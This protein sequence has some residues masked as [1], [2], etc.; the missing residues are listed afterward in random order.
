MQ[1]SFTEAEQFLAVL[2]HGLVD[3]VKY[4]NDFILG[5]LKEVTISKKVVIDVDG[6][7]LQ[8]TAIAHDNY[9]LQIQPVNSWTPSSFVTKG[10]YV[11]DIV[12]GAITLDQ[13]LSSNKIM[14]KGTLNDLLGIYRLAIGLLV[15]GPTS[16]HL[17]GIWHEFD[18]NWHCHGPN[19]VLVNL[20]LQQVSNY[21]TSL[22]VSSEINNVEI[23]YEAE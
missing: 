7:K 17:R 13:A 3:H 11:R 19:N 10:D 12:K 1:N 23:R 14:L 18:T 4:D 20:E 2:F 22:D 9:T 6:S 21:F 8:L 5:L 15:E 16:P